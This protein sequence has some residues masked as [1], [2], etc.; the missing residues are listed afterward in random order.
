MKTKTIKIVALCLMVLSATFSSYAQTTVKTTESCS[1]KPAKIAK[2]KVP[3][4]V[5]E[6]YYKEYP[7]TTYENWYGYPE[8]DYEN[9]WY[10]YNPYLFEYE[11]P[12]YYV[13]EFTKDKIPHRV[14]YSK[15]GKKIAVHKKITSDLP[16][17]V[18]LAISKSE[19]STWKIATEKEEIFRDSDTDK[20]KVYKVEVEK[21]KEKHH[22]FYS[23]EGVLLKDK[24]MKP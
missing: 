15:A 12:E 24:T 21:G 23:S 11:H 5:T 18:S 7:V 9:D 2:T 20:M 14:I 4:V 16:K 22:L 17:V 8:F 13:V 1:K 3:S 10:G 19:Y 6:T